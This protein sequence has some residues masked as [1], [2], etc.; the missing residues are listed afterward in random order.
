MVLAVEPGEGHSVATYAKLGDGMKLEAVHH[1]MLR[2]RGQGDL[3]PSPR[4]PLDHREKAAGRKAV[5]A[6]VQEYA[7]L[8]GAE[9]EGFLGFGHGRSPF[10]K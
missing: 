5:G 4:R 7:G 2:A 8:D 10:A 1:E 9:S 3:A 6:K